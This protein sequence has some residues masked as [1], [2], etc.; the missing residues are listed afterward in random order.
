MMQIV[1]VLLRS[2]CEGLLF[3]YSPYTDDTFTPP[4]FIRSGGMEVTRGPIRC[5]TCSITCS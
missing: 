1:Y 4:C 2:K 5:Q 3:G